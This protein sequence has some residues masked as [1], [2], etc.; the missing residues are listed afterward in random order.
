M[1][2]WLSTTA[3]KGVARVE[4]VRA[5]LG[6]LNFG[7]TALW[8]LRPF[9]GPVYAWRLPRALILIFRFLSRALEG[10]GRAA[11]VGQQRVH[12]MEI[13]RADAKAEGNEVWVGG[14]AIDDPDPDS[15]DGSLNAC[16]MRQ[17]PDFSRLANLIA[18][19]QPWN[20]WPP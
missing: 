1:I 9:L 11:P 10:D 18:R 4:D 5:V 17:L 19:S 13:F 14:W 2:R 12:E 3:D 16:T 6:R 20:S 15:A 8:H 7:F